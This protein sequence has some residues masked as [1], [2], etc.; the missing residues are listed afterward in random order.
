MPARTSPTG[1]Q[2][3]SSMVPFKT[4]HLEAFLLSKPFCS[5]AC[6]ASAP[7]LSEPLQ[8]TPRNPPSYAFGTPNQLI[9]NNMYPVPSSVSV[10]LSVSNVYS[11]SNAFSL[12][13]HTG[14]EQRKCTRKSLLLLQALSPVAQT[15][16][17]T[18]PGV[19]ASWAVYCGLIALVDVALIIACDGIGTFL[20]SASPVA[21]NTVQAVLRGDGLKPVC[22]GWPAR[23]LQGHL[24]S[25]SVRPLFAYVLD[26]HTSWWVLARSTNNRTA[27]H[28]PL[29]LPC[30]LA[31]YS[32]ASAFKM[33]VELG[34][35][36]IIAAL[37]GTSH[38]LLC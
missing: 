23:M 8:L 6:R 26:V 17:A 30:R 15:P 36:L 5:P 2:Q 28:S 16:L 33:F 22:A 12:C 9:P 3:V 38:A 37:V 31:K 4:S 7:T 20:S 24:R 27:R 32:N 21:E 34:L 13:V 19:C 29:H 25:A 14:L 11:R 1:P 35:I 10:G 18:L